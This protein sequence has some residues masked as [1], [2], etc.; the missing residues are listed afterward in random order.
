MDQLKDFKPS[1]ENRQNA[2]TIHEAE[3]TGDFRY[4]YLL[5]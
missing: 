1:I 4:D 2:D 5:K 3:L